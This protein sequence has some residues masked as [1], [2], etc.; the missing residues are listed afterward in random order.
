MVKFVRM[1][2]RLWVRHQ[3]PMRAAALTYTLL[4]SLVPL[5]AVCLSVFSL[6]VD[7]NKLSLTFKLFLFKYLA[8]G[9]GTAVGRTIDG[10]LAK[11]HFKA[12]GYVGFGLLLLFSLMMLASIEDSIN[13]IWAIRRKKK[14]WK[15]VII[16]NLILF[17]G[18]V[19]VSLSLATATVV[20]KYFPQL[21][22][23]A[24]LGVL[25]IGTLFLTLTY[26]IFPNKKVSWLA[27]LFSGLLVAL[28]SELA[29]WGYAGYMAKMLIHNKIY[30]TLAVF[31]L[32]LIWIYV[33][34]VLFLAG[35]LL[36]FMLQHY[37]TFQVN[38]QAKHE[39]YDPPSPADPRPT[40]SFSDS[41]SDS[42]SGA[43]GAGGENQSK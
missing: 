16:Y 33:N 35:A 20:S 18:P 43:N 2:M 13:R 32:F 3:I 30:G 25:V 26:K 1:Y 29:K 19:S 22:P 28:A 24:N 40:S 31:P 23:K 14:L 12:I 37:G 10:F 17:L 15:R 7:V 6:V 8:T 42:S 38:E 34:W 27:A 4:L 41:S 9:A 5:I 39:E 21:L 11:V 36:T